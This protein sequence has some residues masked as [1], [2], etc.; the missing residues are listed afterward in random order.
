LKCTLA[1]TAI[2]LLVTSEL[3]SPYYGKTKIPIDKQK[4]KN[5]KLIVEILFLVTIIIRI[6]AIN[7]SA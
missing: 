1:V 2:I 5:A 6:Y 4:L 3:V 7:I